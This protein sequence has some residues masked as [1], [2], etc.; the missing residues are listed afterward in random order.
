MSTE[1]RKT[2]LAFIDLETGGFNSRIKSDS[3]E[4]T[5]LYRK[6]PMGKVKTMLGTDYHPIFEV[7]CI[8]T[9]EELNVLDKVHIVVKQEQSALKRCHPEA[10]KMHEKSGLLQSS[11]NGSNIDLCV[12]EEIICNKLKEMGCPEEYDYNNRVKVVL[13]G[14]SV[15][16]DRGYIMCQMEKL[17]DMLSHQHMDI[18]VAGQSVRYW[19]PTKNYLVKKEYKHEALNDILE[20]IAE[21]REF[22]KIVVRDAGNDWID[23]FIDRTGHTASERALAIELYGKTHSNRIA[24]LMACATMY[25]DHLEEVETIA[26]AKYNV[27]WR[28]ALRAMDFRKKEP[29]V[30]PSKMKELLKAAQ[31][32]DKE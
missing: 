14:S 17:N 23:N 19:H 24:H 7:A 32:Q 15:H 29:V 4:N 20:T 18:S 6:D 12:A 1:K 16:F 27:W 25:Y 13:A 11:L 5:H 9:D 30:T 21:A 3:I 31:E 28:K 26:D 22:R 2:V 8:F 10:I